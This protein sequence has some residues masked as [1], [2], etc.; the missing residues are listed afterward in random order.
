[1]AQRHLGERLALR[2][3]WLYRLQGKPVLA[4]PSQAKARWDAVTRASAV[5]LSRADARMPDGDHARREYE[6]PSTQNA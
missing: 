1:V 3:P 2:E 4:L 5:A 6:C